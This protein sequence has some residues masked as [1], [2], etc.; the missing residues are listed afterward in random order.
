MKIR[1]LIGPA[2]SG[3]T[4][5]VLDEIRSELKRAQTG[6]PL[7]FI[8]P[9]QASYLV[10]REIFSSGEIKGYSRLYITSFQTFCWKLIDILDPS[11]SQKLRN[12]L[13]SDLTRFLLVKRVVS[14]LEERSE[15]NYLAN[16]LKY[17]GTALE[18]SDLVSELIRNKITPDALSLLLSENSDEESFAKFN[19]VYKIYDAYT[20]LL[21]KRSLID[22]QMVI[23]IC[24]DLLRAYGDS[25]NPKSWASAGSVDKNSN[26]YLFDGIWVDGLSEFSSSELDLLYALAMCTPGLTI[27]ICLDR[28]Y[29]KLPPWQTHWHVPANTL[30]RCIQRF[31]TRPDTDIET[32]VLQIRKG[33]SRFIKNPALECIAKDWANAETRFNIPEASKQIR[34]IA[35]QDLY[36]EVEVA[37]KE[38]MQHV[39]AGGRFRECLVIARNLD[40]YDAPI[41]QVFNRYEIPFYLDKRL[42]ARTH[43]I[44]KF[45]VGA[46]KLAVTEWETNDVLNLLKSG[47]FSESDDC[48][49][50]VEDIALKLGIES[51]KWLAE[52]VWK[53]FGPEHYT[54]YSLFIL[55]LSTIIKPLLNDDLITGAKIK[56]V[57]EALLQFLE[58]NDYQRAIIGDEQ[59]EKIIR[60]VQQILCVIAAIYEDKQIHKR[61][62]LDIL[63]KCLSRIEIPV[64]P[65]KLDQVIIGQIDRLRAPE[66]EL[67]IVLGLNDENFPAKPSV[68]SIISDEENKFVSKIGAQLYKNI[69]S[70]LS[71]EEYLAYIAFTR[72]RNRLVIT[73]SKMDTEGNAL[74]RSIFINKLQNILPNLID[75]EETEIINEPLSK[76]VVTDLIYKYV[77]LNSGCDG[78]NLADKVVAQKINDWLITCRNIKDYHVDVNKTLLFKFNELTIPVTGIEAYLCCPFKFFASNILKIQRRKIYQLNPA[79]EGEFFH[80]VMKEFFQR[81][82]TSGIDIRKL[83]YNEVDELI[84]NIRSELVP[85]YKNGLLVAN[86]YNEYRVQQLVERIKLLIWKMVLGSRTYEFHPKV[87]ELEFK[88]QPNCNSG[89]C[90]SSWRVGECN[91]IK[92]FV[93][94]RIDRVDIIELDDPDSKTL[95]VVVDYKTSNDRFKDKYIES[96]IQIQLLAYL[97]ALSEIEET[98]VISKHRLIPAGAYFLNLHEKV[99]DVTCDILDMQRL[100]DNKDEYICAFHDK[101]SAIINQKYFQ[102]F[103]RSENEKTN[104][105]WNMFGIKLTKDNQIYKRL[106]S[107]KDEDEFNRLLDVTRN[108]IIYVFNRVIKGDMKPWP[109]YSKEANACLRCEYESICRFEPWFDE[110]HFIK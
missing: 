80:F 109:Y 37:A 82:V 9:R 48:I 61:N 70:A 12:N 39:I 108:N 3:K 97:C 50:F 20:K 88:R 47:I 32:V 101:T 99:K 30:L 96:G 40:V 84:D 11:L 107:V 110:Y 36:H 45:I 76:P 67:S 18:L 8:L 85:S 94:G 31:Q 65:D 75:E 43:P 49:D 60:Q 35:C 102:Y 29:E 62:W 13:I 2:G 23:S 98:T 17:T 90:I 53:S 106:N 5:T 81:I 7:I 104:Q 52:D 28:I 79:I 56:E 54:F 46:I 33:K 22:S 73:Y 91:G 16:S 51:E 59:S 83:S 42:S 92:C 69:K 66:V 4:Y 63:D 71:Y 38:I 86:K 74:N 1:F 41:K 21:C 87:M 68:N 19:D 77:Y 57:V 95:F 72:S 58:T 26:E 78:I 14:D 6:K 89:S 25:V 10:E 34:I 103:Y 93:E 44:I 105:G 15:L 24:A 64:I 55:Q 27:A 100:K